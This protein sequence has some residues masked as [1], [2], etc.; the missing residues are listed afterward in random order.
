MPNLNSLANIPG[1]GA[2]VSKRQMNEQAGIQDLQEQSLLMG[3]KQKMQAQQ[4]EQQLQQSLSESGGDLEAAMAA[5]L[6][7]GRADVASKLGSIMSARKEKQ[8]DQPEIVKL[9]AAIEKLPQ[10]HP[11]RALLEARAK[12]LTDVGGTE[13]RVSPLGRLIQERDKLPVGDPRR[14][15]YDAA[16]DRSGGPGVNVSVN[17]NI[18]LGKE[19]SNKVDTG[20]LDTTQ[21]LMKLSAI[22]GQ[23]KP[24][25]QQFGPRLSA[26][27]ASIRE[28]MGANINPQ[29]KQF[30]AEFSA[31][32]RNAV[33]AMNEY[34]KSITGA[35]MSE[36]EAQRILRGMPNPGQGV[37]DGDSPTE[38]K[39]KLDDAMRQTKLSLARYEYIKRNGIALTDSNGNSV[40]PLERMPEIMNSR[41]KALEDQIKKANPNADPTSIQNSV[42]GILAKEFGLV[43]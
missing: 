16:I 36:A 3:L 6:K 15:A 32:K 40:V 38:F 29:D 1:Y 7:A 28:K 4:Q 31:Y 5:A 33:N 18:S 9:Q 21:G 22:E 10:G 39:A 43:R 37:F 8:F 12:K 23:F 2:F 13:E 34:I 42:K 24:E 35:A 25:Y 19:A 26:G 27:W 14:K 30:L 20:L 11:S 17:P 41:G